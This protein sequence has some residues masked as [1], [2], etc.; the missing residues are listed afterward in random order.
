MAIHSSVLKRERQNE[1]RRKRNRIIK[2]KIHT[3]FKRVI[4][5]IQAK[6]KE[7]IDKK[8]KNYYSEIDK[9]VKRGIF[10]KN[11]AARKKSRIT[12]K[13]NESLK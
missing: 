13:V 7:D 3:A 5:A 11:K 10:H 6:N 9:G 1:T 4:E 8:L 12:K 2:S